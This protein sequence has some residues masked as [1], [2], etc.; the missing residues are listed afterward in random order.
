[1]V[2]AHDGALRRG[3][4]H[5][6]HQRY[7]RQVSV[8]GMRGQPDAVDDG[9]EG[10]DER[11]GLTADDTRGH[12]GAGHDHRYTGQL[13]VHVGFAPQ[14]A[15]AEVVAVIAGVDDARVAGEA[16]VLERLQ[17]PADI[18][19]DEAD[20]TEIGGN[21]FAHF[22]RIIESLVVDLAGSHGLD[23]RVGRP[24]GL[25]VQPWPWHLVLGIKVVPLGPRDQG[26]VRAD[27]GDE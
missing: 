14:S 25:G 27:E 8:V 22:G 19:V 23:I 20:E 9:G 7:A 2:L 5:D 1:M 26:K 6:V 3:A 13:L 10:I 21:R 4:A 15:R 11:D 17:E 18:V 16:V 12:L 24:L